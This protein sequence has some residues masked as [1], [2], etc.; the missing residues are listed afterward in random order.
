[1][2]V[3]TQVLDVT[4]AVAREQQAELFTLPAAHDELIIADAIIAPPDKFVAL[5]YQ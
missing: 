5:R 2:I 1:M 4:E 3:R